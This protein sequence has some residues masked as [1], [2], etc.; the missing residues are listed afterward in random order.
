MYL[1]F[2]TWNSEK[3]IPPQKVTISSRA[4]LWWGHGIDIIRDHRS[5]EAKSLGDEF[6]VIHTVGGLITIDE[7]YE[8]VSKKI[9]DANAEFQNSMKVDEK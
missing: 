8:S 1:D 5:G 6:T 3:I 2:K 9:R 7:D 4:I